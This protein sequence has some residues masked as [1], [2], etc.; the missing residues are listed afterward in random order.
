[1]SN[2][3]KWYALDLGLNKK[4]KPR[5]AVVVEKLKGDA[6]VIIK[7]KKNLVPMN[8]TKQPLMHL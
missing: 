4:R 6:A 3:K 8:F 5:V 7:M 1:M 2:N